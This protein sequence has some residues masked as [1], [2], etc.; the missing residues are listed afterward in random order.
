MDP[1]IETADLQDGVPTKE[2]DAELRVAKMEL[3]GAEP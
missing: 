2:H 1:W 3:V